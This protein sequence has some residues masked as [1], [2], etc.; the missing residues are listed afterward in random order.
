M[1][2]TSFICEK[3]TLIHL[4]VPLVCIVLTLMIDLSQYN[5]DFNILDF[6]INFTARSSHDGHLVSFHVLDT[7]I[8]QQNDAEYDL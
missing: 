4:F 3:I 2:N 1:E 6:T 5:A 7:I 8:H